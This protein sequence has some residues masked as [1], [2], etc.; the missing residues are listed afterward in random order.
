MNLKKLVAC[1]LLLF[2]LC[3]NAGYGADA[4]ESHSGHKRS[5]TSWVKPV[6]ETFALS[7]VAVISPESALAIAVDKAV[8]SGGLKG[9][10]DSVVTRYLPI[11]P[12]I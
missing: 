8:N 7:A 4:L 11:K 12:S 2:S 9:A 6:C 5:W 10:L 1:N 3:T